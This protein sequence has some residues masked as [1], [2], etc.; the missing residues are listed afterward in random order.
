LPKNLIG[1]RKERTWLKYLVWI[2]IDLIKTKCK[3]TITAI[4]EAIPP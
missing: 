1:K 4:M 2:I 3:K